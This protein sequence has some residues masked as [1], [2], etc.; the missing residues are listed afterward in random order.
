MECF[1]VLLLLAFPAVLFIR[2]KFIRDYFG[3]GRLPLILGFIALACI[4]IQWF[5]FPI[6]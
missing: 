5:V 3:D 6:R 2:P 4:A 1:Q